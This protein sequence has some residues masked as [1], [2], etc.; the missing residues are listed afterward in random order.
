MANLK[1]YN[2]DR[3][4]QKSFTIR[5]VN[6]LYVAAMIEVKTQGLPSLP[7]F[8]RSLLSAVCIDKTYGGFT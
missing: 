8:V 1:L 7:D 5:C 2:P 6:E 4:F 3:A